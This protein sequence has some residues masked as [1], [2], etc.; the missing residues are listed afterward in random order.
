MLPR[1]EANLRFELHSKGL[2][3]AKA[4]VNGL[5]ITR[6]ENTGGRD[7]ARESRQQANWIIGA[8]IT[9][10]LGIAGLAIS[11]GVQ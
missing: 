4:I 2:D 9:I 3:D 6:G 8:A 5:L 10:G 1:E 11:L 7:H